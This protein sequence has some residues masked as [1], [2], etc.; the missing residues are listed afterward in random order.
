[1]RENLVEPWDKAMIRAEVHSGVV[2]LKGGYESSGAYRS[3]RFR[4]FNRRIIADFEELHEVTTEGQ[5]GR[6]NRAQFSL[7]PDGKFSIDFLWDQDLADEIA[8][9]DP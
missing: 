7:Q 6:W 8:G 9:S 5:E 3:F 4:D 2:R 1:M